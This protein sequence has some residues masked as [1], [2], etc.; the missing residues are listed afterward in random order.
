MAI[1]HG[2]MFAVAGPQC[3]VMNGSRGGDQGIPQFDGVTPG[4]LAQIVS[5]APPDLRT[6]GNTSE[7]AEKRVENLVLVR[8]RSMPY[9]RHGDR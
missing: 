8:P 4:E 9:F 3:K 1:L 6:D 2:V 7:G 5:G